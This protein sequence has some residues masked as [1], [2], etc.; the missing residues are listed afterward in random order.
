MWD[1]NPRDVQVFIATSNLFGVAPAPAAPDLLSLAAQ[2]RALAFLIEAAVQA[3]KREGF[4]F[5]LPSQTTA[6]GRPPF[7]EFSAEAHGI[8]YWDLVQRAEQGGWDVRFVK[9]GTIIQG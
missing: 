3:Y 2:K 1:P 4:R 7:K 5:Y 6:D 9:D 8:V